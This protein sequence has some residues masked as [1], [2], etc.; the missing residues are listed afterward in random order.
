MA[1]DFV[2]TFV[3]ISASGGNAAVAAF[4]ATNV[5]KKV[6]A[7]PTFSINENLFQLVIMA[8]TSTIGK[9][10]AVGANA[11]SSQFEVTGDGGVALVAA[12]NVNFN[13]SPALTKVQGVEVA[14]RD[15]LAF[16]SFVQSN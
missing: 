13:A 1:I 2:S 3:N 6:I 4:I 15:N 5:G 14:L 16:V 11:A 8:T 9:G 10:S 12:M 7:I